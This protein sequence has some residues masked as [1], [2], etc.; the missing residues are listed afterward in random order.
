MSKRKRHNE[1]QIHAIL[2][3]ADAGLK[4]AELCRKYGMTQSRSAHGRG[5][6][7]SLSRADGRTTPHRGLRQSPPFVRE[8]CRGSSF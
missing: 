6:G 8:P 3:E 7:L 5:D 1:E 2:K 4:P